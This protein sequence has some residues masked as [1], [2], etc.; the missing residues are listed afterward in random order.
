MRKTDARVYKR[1]KGRKRK[2]EEEGFDIVKKSAQKR[3]T[4]A[5]QQRVKR[6]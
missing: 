6:N 5:E 2:E 4:M 1:K 3:E